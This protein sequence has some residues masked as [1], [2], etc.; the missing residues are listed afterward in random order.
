MVLDPFC[1]TGTTG[2]AAL[3]LGRRFTGI[4]LSPAFAALSAERLRHA[5]QRQPDGSQDGSR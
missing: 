4:E 2:I 1:G 3:A 5:A